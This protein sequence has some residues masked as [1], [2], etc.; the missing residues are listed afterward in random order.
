MSLLTLH[1][2]RI[3]IKMA[4]CKDSLKMSRL[5]LLKNM[6]LGGNLLFSRIIKLIFIGVFFVEL[7]VFIVLWFILALL[8][9]DIRMLENLFF[10]LLISL[11]FCFFCR[12]SLSSLRKNL[13]RKEIQKMNHCLLLQIN[14]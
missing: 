2:Q 8:L 3:F 10:G 1:F 12:L 9:V 5:G 11:S 14:I 4:R 13:M 7:R 6:S